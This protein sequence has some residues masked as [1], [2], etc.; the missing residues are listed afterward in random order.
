MEQKYTK[1]NIKTLYKSQEKVIR[2]FHD[3]CKIAS[4]A[5]YKRICGE[6]FKNLTPDQMLQRLLKVGNTSKNLRN[7]SPLVVGNEVTSGN[8]K[9]FK[10]KK[11][12]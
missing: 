5:K 9:K 11:K 3:Y 1:N 2:L 10:K 8:Q 7:I 12:R 6:K 4:E